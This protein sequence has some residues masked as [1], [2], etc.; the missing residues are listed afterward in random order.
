M[1]NPIIN[2][3]NADNGEQP[4]SWDPVIA[5][6]TVFTSIK[7]TNPVYIR[8][9]QGNNAELHPG[10][11]VRLERINLASVWLWGESG[12]VWYVVGQAG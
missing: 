2:T 8:D 3:F 10:C 5:T 1:A 12:T 11:E 4:L 9:E 7:N 6:V